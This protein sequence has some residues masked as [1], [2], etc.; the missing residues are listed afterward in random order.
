MAYLEIKRGDKLIKGRQ[1]DDALAETGYPVRLGQKRITLHLGQTKQVG[2]YTLS[3]RSDSGM[4][5]NGPPSPAMLVSET[6]IVESDPG[7]GRGKPDAQRP[8]IPGYEI[9]G[10]LGAGGMGSVWLATQLSTNRKVAIKLMSQSFFGSEKAQNRFAREVELTAR[11]DHPNIAKVYDSGLNEGHYFYVMEYIEGHPLDLYIE[12]NKLSQTQVLQL[13]ERVC[14][15]VYHAHLKGIIHRDLKPSNILVTEDGE[16]HVLDLGLAKSFLEND[17][18]VQVS[19]EGDISG[20][21]A[22]MSPEQARGDLKQI[23]MRTDVYSM[24]IILFRLLTGQPPHDLS[25]SRL[26]VLKRVAESEVWRP[27]HIKPDLDSELESLLLKSLAHDPDARYLSAGDMADDIKNYLT[28]EPLSARPATTL[29]FL[30]KKVR[31]HFKKVCLGAAVVLVIL[32][33]GLFAFSQVITSRVRIKAAQDELEIQRQTAELAQAEASSIRDRWQDLELMILEGRSETDVRAAIRALHQEYVTAQGEIEDLKATV[34]ALQ[35]SARDNPDQGLDPPG[36]AVSGHVRQLDGQPI[37]GAT[38]EV[39]HIDGGTWGEAVTKFDGSYR[40]GGIGTGE[41]EV[42]AFKRGFARKYYDNVVFSLDAATIHVAAPEE[43][44]GIEFYLNEGG[45]ISGYVYNGETN[46][47]IQ[48]ASMRVIPSSEEPDDGFHTVTDANGFYQIEYLALGIYSVRAEAAGFIDLW[49]EQ[50]YSPD[51]TKGVR[52]TP[53]ENVPNI[54]FSLYRGGSISGRV[55]DT[56]GIPLEGV[57]VGAGGQLPNGQWI[58]SGTTTVSDGSYTIDN[59][60]PWDRHE[61]GTQKCGF[62]PQWYDSRL[63]QATADHVTVTEGNDTPDINFTLQAGGSI[64][65]HVYSEEDGTPIRGAGFFVHLPT[66]KQVLV[67]GGTDRDGSYTIWLGPGSYLIHTTGR[68]HAAKWYDNSYDAENAAIV[69]V[70]ASAETSGID[71]HLSKAGSISGH[72]YGEEGEP[73]GNATVYASSDESPGSGTNSQP[74]GSY[75]IEG[76][77]TGDYHVEVSVTGHAPESE[78]GIVVNALNNASGIDFMLKKLPPT[79]LETEYDDGLADPNDPNEI[80]AADVFR[81]R[82]G[83][84]N[85]ALREV[86][87][88]GIL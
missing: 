20:T 12:A 31:K 38:V 49:Y 51:P 72:I 81:L 48:E 65:G 87:R 66:G 73:I 45:S 63:T 69:H 85:M 3:L 47:P 86:A 24:G 15:A 23:D 84:T 58:G 80:A 35:D 54:N 53:P 61:V 82:L 4:T 5:D 9:T 2:P 50:R 78:R 11:L 33:V 26:E 55:V 52:V 76:L 67:I 56:N 22:Y 59:L 30:Q 70:K 16:P 44:T 74:D 39:L 46:E 42:R 28:G 71:F 88:V 18:D 6:E 37:S 57:H 62:V 41:Y 32:G 68:G 36:G 10:R 64:T 19:I 60:P 79:D 27:R 77:P 34:A 1:V 21:P 13:M 7:P 40:V 75:I 14:K 83:P 43:I 17:T 25:G 29:Y 8:N